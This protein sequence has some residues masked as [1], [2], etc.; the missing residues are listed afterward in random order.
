MKL[1]PESTA[2][3]AIHCQGT[4][5]ADYSDVQADSPLLQLAQGKRAWW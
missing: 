3:V 5:G 1:D 2:L 4:T